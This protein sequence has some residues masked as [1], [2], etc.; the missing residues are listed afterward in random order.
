M[1]L[2]ASAVF[3]V[4]AALVLGACTAPDSRIR[5]THV[6]SGRL[7]NPDAEETTFLAVLNDHRAALG[8]S[9]LVSTPL[10]NQVAYDHSLDMGLRGYFDHP[11]LEGRSP[12]DRMKAAGYDGGWMGENIAAGHAGGAA[13]F[14]QW[15]ISPSHYANMVETHYRAIGIGRA[16]VAGSPYRWYWTTD[17][18]DYVDESVNADVDAGADG[19]DASSPVR[20][21]SRFTP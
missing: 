19:P 4:I 6:L 17:F 5:E 16:Y 3:L 2:N 18:G 11:D 14:E 7:R 21:A 13:T 9:P 10:L 20:S 15:R 1:R 8:L 12:F